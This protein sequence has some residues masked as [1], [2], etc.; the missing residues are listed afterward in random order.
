MSWDARDEAYLRAA[1]AQRSPPVSPASKGGSSRSLCECDEECHCPEETLLLSG[2]MPELQLPGAR[3]VG[4]APWEARPVPMLQPPPRIADRPG[5]SADIGGEIAGA[6]AMA[7]QVAVPEVQV[8]LQAQRR[9]APEGVVRTDVFG[10]RRRYFEPREIAR[11]N[12]PDDCWLVAHGKVF[13][14]TTFLQQHPA[15][16]FAILR[17]AGTDS[18]TDFDFHSGRAQRMWAPYMLGYVDTGRGGDCCIS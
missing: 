12:Q 10:R 17:H 7:A 9:R 5:P 1:R 11:H 18:T 2:G 8:Q 6:S 13:D 14:V 3:S 16:E 15:G 4:E